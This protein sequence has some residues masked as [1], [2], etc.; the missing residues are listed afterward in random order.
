MSLGEEG[1][2]G[3]SRT[4]A[5]ECF[6]LYLCLG[7]A[8][9]KIKASESWAGPVAG[10]EGAQMIAALLWPNKYRTFRLLFN[11]II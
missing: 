3:Y 11:L 9:E 10:V 1:R 7:G 2:P 6:H 4:R 5:H 8:P